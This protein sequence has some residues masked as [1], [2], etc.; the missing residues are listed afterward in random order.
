MV[1]AKATG[2]LVTDNLLAGRTLFLLGTGTGFA[3]FA[4]I[5]R[6]PETYDRFERVVL[7]HGCRTVAELACSE[8]VVREVLADEMTA[9]FAQGKLLY[10][11]TTTR[12]AFRHEGRITQLLTTDR[13]TDDLG[14]GPLD[15]AQDRV[16]LCGSPA[17]LTDL[18]VF[19]RERGFIGSTSNI[20]GSYAIERAFV[21]R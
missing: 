8:E 3:P 11:P 5:V 16:M 2:T 12:E 20:Q 17:M 14:L 4:S 7:V 15:A 18:E 9:E 21:E 6:A 13:L 19:L 1:G 10:Y